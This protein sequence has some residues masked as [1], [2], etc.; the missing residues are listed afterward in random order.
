MPA[1]SWSKQKAEI[2]AKEVEKE[3]GGAWTYFDPRVKE[4]MLD[5]KVMGIVLRYEGDISVDYIRVLRSNIATAMADLGLDTETAKA[6]QAVEI[7]NESWS[8][9]S[10]G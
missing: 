5:Y 7:W 3:A 2:Y 6:A 8:D 1:D 4:A 9:S 10:D